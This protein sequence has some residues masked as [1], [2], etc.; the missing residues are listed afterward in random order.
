[1]KKKSVFCT[2]TPI[3][4]HIPRQLAIDMLHSH[5]EII[6]LNPLVIEVKA[7]K[8]P[9]SAPPDEFFSTWYEITE[10]IKF[11]PG[12]GKAGTGKISFNGC[13]HDMPW[14]LQ[15]HVY[16]PMGVDLRNKW[17]I[18][19]NQQGEPPETR[20]L[21]SGA[22]SSG[23][24]LREDI[25]IRCNPAVVGFVK[26]EM[27][28][29]SKTMVDRLV[30]KAE[31]IDA[32]VLSAMFDQGKL[33]TSNPADRSQNAQSRGHYSP[34]MPPGSPSTFPPVSPANPAFPQSAY[35]Y[36][37]H[38]NSAHPNSA[39]PQSAYARQSQYGY[40]QP[41]QGLAIEMPGSTHFA[42][43]PSQQQ[44]QQQQLQAHGPRFSSAM[45]ELSAHSPQ[46]SQFQMNGSASDRQS[47]AASVSS[48]PSSYQHGDDRMYSP[49]NEKRA[50]VAELPGVHPHENVARDPPRTPDPNA[51]YNSQQTPPQTSQQ[52]QQPPPSQQGTPAFQ[53]LPSQQRQYS[54]NPQDYARVS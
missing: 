28:A 22:P 5:Q 21:G 31:L 20:E 43:D 18:R 3:P 49:G 50:F 53:G 35:P 6:E 40:L 52:Q 4:S 8:A 39:H 32:G 15:T 42:P 38:P 51:T 16:A 41:P 45:S 25:E 48:H 36:S 11:I 7:I 19:G 2:I 14:G 37:A 10:R 29:S 33:K 13:F 44:Q 54:Y 17:Q 26:K 12:I 34:G 47:Y 24:Y 9:Q 46:Q 1:M 23:L 27:K 30:K